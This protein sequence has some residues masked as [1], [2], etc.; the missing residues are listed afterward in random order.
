MV[1][2]TILIPVN[3]H[4]EVTVDGILYFRDATC[5]WKCKEGKTGSFH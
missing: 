5:A 4:V 2:A 1:N 3:V